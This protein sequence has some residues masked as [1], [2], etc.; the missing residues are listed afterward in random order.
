MFK[1]QDILIYIT[2][3]LLA[4]AAYLIHTGTH[5]DPGMTVLVTVDGRQTIVCPLSHDLE[6][7][8]SGYDGGE[9]RLVISEGKAYVESSSCPDK[10]CVKHSP[11]SHAEESIICLPNRVVVEI[12]AGEEASPIDAVSQ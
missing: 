3:L 1:K 8:V 5:R 10:I 12:L 6:T 2:V 11:V 9:L 4:G 7:T